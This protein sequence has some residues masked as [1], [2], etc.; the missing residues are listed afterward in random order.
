MHYRKTNEE[1]STGAPPPKLYRLII[2]AFVTGFLI[3][4]LES[5]CTGQL[6]LPTITFVLKE[7]SLRLRALAYLLLYNFMFILPL[8]GILILALLGTTQEGFSRFMKEH[9]SA[10]KLSMAILFF[11][12]G[13]FILLAA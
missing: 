9:L 2:S 8:G 11:V 1:K 3:S 6:Y 7:S 12:L 13:I 10:V 5:V 4:L